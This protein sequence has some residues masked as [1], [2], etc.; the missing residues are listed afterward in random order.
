MRYVYPNRSLNTSRSYCKTTNVDDHDLGLI[1]VI[2]C[3]WKS[4]YVK[5]DI[6]IIYAPCTCPA[7]STYQFSTKQT[8]I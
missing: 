8:Y 6:Y 2:I 4:E 3:V 5:I 7:L 1:H